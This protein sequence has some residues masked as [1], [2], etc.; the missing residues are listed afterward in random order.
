M[1]TVHVLFML[2]LRVRTGASRVE[3]G[4]ILIRLSSNR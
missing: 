1:S 4:G 3:V 2:I